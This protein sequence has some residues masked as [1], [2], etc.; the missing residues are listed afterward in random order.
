MTK[1]VS[2]FCFQILFGAA[3]A[4]ADEQESADSPK[5]KRG[6]QGVYH[7][8]T[9]PFS[10]EPRIIAPAPLPVAHPF[11]YPPPFPVAAPLP[12]AAPVPVHAPLP[13]FPPP[14]FAPSAVAFPAPVAYPAPVYKVPVPVPVPARLAYFPGFAKKYRIR[15]RIPPLLRLSL[16]D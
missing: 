10:I 4:R 13:V 15:V 12:V 14:H 16:R 1:F 7:Y 3:L 2:T 8:A 11:P 5:T 9:G 6:V